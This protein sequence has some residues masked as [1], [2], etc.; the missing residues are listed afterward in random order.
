MRPRL[1][2]LEV[3]RRANRPIPAAKFGPSRRGQQ[4]ANG[5][6]LCDAVVS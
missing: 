2:A 3:V 1:A 6:L 4:G 5:A